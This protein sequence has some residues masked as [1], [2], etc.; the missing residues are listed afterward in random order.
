MQTAFKFLTISLMFIS[1]TIDFKQTLTPDKSE[2]LLSGV[3][4]YFTYSASVVPAS[5]PII[6]IDALL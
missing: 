6:S 3:F 5:M 1:R 4:F 2:S